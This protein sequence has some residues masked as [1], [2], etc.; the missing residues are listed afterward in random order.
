MAM[1][2]TLK[3]GAARGRQAGGDHG[4]DVF[5]RLDILCCVVVCSVGR[6]ML[7]FFCDVVTHRW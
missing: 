7:L 2:L 5:L 6:Y 1:S 3:I 4:V